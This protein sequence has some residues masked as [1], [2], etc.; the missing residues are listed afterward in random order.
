MGKF[1]FSVSAETR[2]LSEYMSKP[3]RRLPRDVLEKAKDHILDT[4]ASMISGSRLKAGLLAIPYV[5]GLG[6]VREANIVGT[7]IM[8]SAAN[9]AFANG[10]FAHAD[11]TDDSHPSSFT[12]PGS[13]IVPAAL[14]VAE[15]ERASG[16]EF[17][18]AVVLGY[19][20]GC[21]L[22]KSLD[23][24][25]FTAV[26]RSSH[27]F[28]GTFGAGAAAGSL[29]RFNSSKARHLLSYCAQLASGCGAYMHD[30]GHVEKAFVYSGKSAQAGVTAAMLIDAGFTGADDVFSGER[31]FLDAYAGQKHPEELSSELGRRYEIMG[32]NIKKWS[33]GSPIQA[34][35]DSIEGISEDGVIPPQEVESVHVYLPPRE[36]R[37]V[38]NRPFS[39]V[40]VQHLVALMLVDGKLNFQSIHDDRRMSDPQ[41]RAFK[42][43]VY[44]VPTGSLAS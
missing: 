7:R 30:K 28:G 43:R 15:K 32:T 6:G 1:N 5:R 41:I 42:R 44:L 11:E 12:H 29:L 20:V 31:N 3:P 24:R 19:D 18:H 2:A 33:V 40:N 4:F 27:S 17:L 22:T 9:A 36:S 23:I 13:A 26:F 37:V 10:M 35:L 16:R 25:A 34:V 21:R 38:D 8:T 14:A 39:D